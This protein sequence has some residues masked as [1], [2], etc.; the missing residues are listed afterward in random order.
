MT[1]AARLQAAIDILETLEHATT[2]ADRTIE[3]WGRA[4]R[5]AGSKDR[6]AIAERVYSA[7][8]RRR[9]FA[10]RMHGLET[11]RALVIAATLLEDRLHAD[12]IE[13]LFNGDGYGPRPLSKDERLAIA[14]AP[15]QCTDPATRLNIPDWLLPEL[16][17][18]FDHDL[19]TEA[20]AL[21]G[22]AATDIRANTILTTRDKLKAALEEEG[23]ILDPTPHAPTGLRVESGAGKLKRSVPFHAGWF[24]LQD[25][26]SQCAALMLGA[27]PG[28]HIV[29]LC[30]G[31]GGKSLAIAAAM[32]NQGRITSCDTVSAKLDEHR[33]RAKRAGLH[34]LETRTLDND[35]LHHDVLADIAGKI[36]RVI[37]DAPCSGSGTW[38]RNPESKWRLT[39][40]QLAAYASVQSQLLSAAAK[41]LKPGGTLLYVTCS[42]LPAE[43]E[44]IAA[45]FLETHHH[46][47]PHDANERWRKLVSP[48]PPPRVNRYAR[49]S[50]ASSQTDAF[51][52]A[53]FEKKEAI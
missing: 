20:A 48:T 13:Q 24:E 18:A 28:E 9:E 33:I 14:T 49:L 53:A 22:R 26:G 45:R 51:F 5:F 3:A 11:P 23:V 15:T 12:E 2:P 40:D 52:I 10:Y 36:D 8:R 38:R 50:P 16:T 30:A 32:Q 46:F 47:E 27:Q 44:S 4:H 25:D 31:A 21:T 42:L 35:W 1:P 19:E 29:D 6:A 39:A 41:L 7:L 37:V 34:V 17:R 43:N